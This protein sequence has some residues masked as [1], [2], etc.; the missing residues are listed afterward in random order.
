MFPSKLT[1]SISPRGDVMPYDTTLRRCA[2]PLPTLILER[3]LAQ[4]V[5]SIS[6]FLWLRTYTSIVHSSNMSNP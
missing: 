2:S 6:F 5:P 4:E 1:L 3:L